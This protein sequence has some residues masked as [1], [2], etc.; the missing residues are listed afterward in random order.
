MADVAEHCQPQGARVR[1]VQPPILV[2]RIR[3]F[4]LGTS[5]AKLVELVLEESEH[6]I[7]IVTTDPYIFIINTFAFLFLFLSCNQI[8][9]LDVHR[10]DEVGT[11]A[12][13][14]LFP[15]EGFR[16]TRRADGSGTLTSPS[17]TSSKTAEWLFLAH[18]SCVGGG[19]IR[20]TLVHFSFLEENRERSK[21]WRWRRRRLFACLFSNS[22][23]GQAASVLRLR[24]V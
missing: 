23:Q 16:N 13:A 17:S 19:E 9:R 15:R 3:T 4:K 14:L 12:R 8:E 1:A 7:I 21:G 24:V 6:I 2:L 10:L 5:T 22:M 18:D 11:S 20:L